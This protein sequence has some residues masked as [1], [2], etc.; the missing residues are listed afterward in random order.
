M[1]VEKLDTGVSSP[2]SCPMRLAPPHLGGV[3]HRAPDNNVFPQ[4]DGV[5]RIT[6]E[7]ELLSSISINSRIEVLTAPDAFSKLT[8]HTAGAASEPTRVAL[9]SSGGETGL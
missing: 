1:E 2:Q 5:I 9:G 7:L 4:K 3:R 6:Q 8:A